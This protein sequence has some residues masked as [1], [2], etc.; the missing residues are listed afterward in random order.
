MTQN[1]NVSIENRRNNNLK[2]NNDQNPLIKTEAETTSSLDSSDVT[3]DGMLTEFYEGTLTRTES[4]HESEEIK[5]E[6]PNAESVFEEDLDDDETV[7]LSAAPISPMTRHSSDSRRL[8]G[9]IGREI[10]TSSVTR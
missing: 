10:T 6:Q 4:F 9:V 7:G 8:R 1:G 3:T 2:I 5:S